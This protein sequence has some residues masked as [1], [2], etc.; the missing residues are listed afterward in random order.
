MSSH[1]S[2]GGRCRTP[3]APWRR[4]RPSINKSGCNSGLCGG[5]RVLQPRCPA[6]TG[7]AVKCISH[8]HV[9]WAWASSVWGS[10]PAIENHEVLLAV[11]H[12]LDGLSET[13]LSS[14]ERL[15][16]S[17]L[18]LPRL[19]R[20]KFRSTAADDVRMRLSS[21]SL[22]IALW[23]NQAADVLLACAVR[24]EL[25]PARVSVTSWLHA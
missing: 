20:T 25:G 4:F 18:S 15:I 14:V 1:S 19:P 12:K 9:L 17:L 24:G 13:A 2:S 3:S 22:A 10:L 23:R 7:P 6:Q 21:S 16:Q 5:I 11:L 8:C